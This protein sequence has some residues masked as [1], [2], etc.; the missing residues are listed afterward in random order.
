MHTQDPGK[1]TVTHRRLNQTYLVVLEGLHCGGVG[2]QWLTTGPEAQAAAGL[3]A[4]ALLESVNPAI[5]PVDSRAACLRPKNWQEQ[6]Q[7]HHQ[8][9]IGLKFD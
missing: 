5:E 4:L 7:L 8:Q 1:G 3:S 9:T 6:R 2:Q